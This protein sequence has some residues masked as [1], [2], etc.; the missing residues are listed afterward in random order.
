MQKIRVLHISTAKT[1][2]G[3]ETQIQLLMNGLKELGVEQVLFCAAGSEIGRRLKRDYSVVQEVKAG[4]IPI[5]YIKRLKQEILSY[6]PSIIHVHDSHGHTGAVLAHK[7]CNSEIP[8]V[9]HRRV[10]FNIKKG[11]LSGKKYSYKGVKGYIAVSKFIE[12]LIAPDL[13]G[14]MLT[15]IYSSAVVEE[16]PAVGKLRKEL[17]LPPTVKLIGNISA[18]AEHKDI[19]TFVKIAR[20][21]LLKR[22][23]LHFVWI[24]DGPCRLQLE[25]LIKDMESNFTLLGF[26]ADADELLFDLDVFLM[27]SK[28]EGLGTTVIKAMQAGIPVV[29]TNAGG[30]RE[31]IISNETGISAE[32]GDVQSLIRGVET[33]LQEDSFSQEASLRAKQLSPKLMTKATVQFY[34]SLI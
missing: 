24:G 27:T 3:G 12:N 10:D 30:L 26:R 7:W 29:S 25:Q 20:E 28:T 6:K 23:D 2:R 33:V 15:T 19:P 8:I 13:P 11:W 22:S 4:S 34:Q 31:L 14:K 32:V 21:L 1:W 16:P 9:V 18:I 17:N 5:A